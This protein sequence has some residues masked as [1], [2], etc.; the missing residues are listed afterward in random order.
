MGRLRSKELGSEELGQRGWG[1]GVR[2]AGL[3]S[4]GLG[5][6]KLLSLHQIVLAS[7]RLRIKPSYTLGHFGQMG[8]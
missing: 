1:Q 2:V 4:R 5:L 7:N 6:G 8:V 3:G